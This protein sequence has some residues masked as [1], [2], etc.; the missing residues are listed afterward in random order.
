MTYLLEHMPPHMHLI[1][2]TRRVPS[3]L[4]PGCAPG[5]IGRAPCRYLRFSPVEASEF[6]NEVMGLG[7]LPGDVSALETHTEGSIAGLQLAAISVK[8]HEDAAGFIKSFTG[9]HSFVTDY[10]L[11]EVLQ[12]QPEHVQAFLLRTSILGR[13]CGPLCDAVLGDP[14]AQ[15]NRPW[16]TSSAP[17]SFSSPW[18]TNVG[19][20][21]ITISS[22]NC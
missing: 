14:S 21:A 10:L 2:A 20:T 5:P 15:D 11:Q 4:L 8:G 13:L 6:L 9:G 1:I 18:T 7:S 16:N 17:T 3:C 22:R 19:G 12:R